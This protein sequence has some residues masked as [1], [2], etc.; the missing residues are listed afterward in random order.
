MIF[1]IIIALGG[2]DNI[3]ILVRNLNIDVNNIIMRCGNYIIALL[4]SL[5]CTTYA[6]ISLEGDTVW[7]MKSIPITGN[8]IIKSKMLVNLTITIPAAII[9]SLIFSLSYNLSFSEIIINIITQLIFALFVAEWGM[10]VNLRNINFEWTN[11]VQ[12]IKEGITVIIG[13][14]GG[15]ALSVIALTLIYL[16]QDLGY[17][18]VSIIINLV[19]IGILR[20]MHINNIKNIEGIL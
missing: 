19:I 17:M 2:V 18:L 20:A 1:S 8:I 16:S 5:S 4:I 13:I 10:F 14:I 7:I 9:A 11:E 12:V 15:V 6:S 3:E